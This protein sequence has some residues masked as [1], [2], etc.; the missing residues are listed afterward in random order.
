[1]PWRE[2]CRVNERLAFI[3]RLRAGE[4]MT[5]L[6]RDFGISR[7]TGYKL[8][9]RYE[10]HGVEALLD[11]SRAPHA[12]PHQT[13]TAMR[14][15]IIAARRQHPTWGPKKIKAWLARRHPG[16]RVP[17]ASTIGGI[18]TK[19]G[20]VKGRTRRR[21]G[22][23][24][25]TGLRVASAPNELWCADF[26]GQFQL[27]NGRY[28]YP[29]TITDA[30]SRYLIACVALDGTAGGPTQT[31]FEDA[32]REHGLPQAIRTDNGSPFA[33]TGIA[34]L[35]ALSAW[36][37]RLGVEP[38][39]IEPGHPEQNGQ[40][41]RMHRTLKAETTRP[42]GRTLLQQQERFDDFRSEFNEERPHEALGQETP[43]SRYQSSI[44][45]LEEA[46][47]YSAYPLHDYVLNVTTKGSIWLRKEIFPQRCVYLGQ[48]FAGHSVG[49]REEPNGRW[50]VSF[51]SLDLGYLDPEVG[52]DPCPE[53]L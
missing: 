16:L 7:K 38:E 28:C 22:K 52:F 23:S 5:D 37:I 30:Y 3:A 41:E 40:H 47:E 19:A 13:P 1:M 42:A 21:K 11:Q 25:P 20:L 48:A 35:T 36:W 34:G 29:L 9:Q 31:V 4:R 45:H 49:L 51:M 14:E 8:K 33:S 53:L 12:V 39:R 24:K 18:L 26:K 2:T 17:A 15:L 44:R 50:L 6:C 27:R 32:F 10:A 46:W 43:S